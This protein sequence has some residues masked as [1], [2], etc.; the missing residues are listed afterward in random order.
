M[1]LTDKDLLSIQE[2]R[3]L[4]KQAKVAQRELA[5]LSQEEIDLIV[6]TMAKSAYANRIKLAKMAHKETGFGR[7]QDKVLKNAFASRDVLNA[8]KDMKT[9]GVINKSEEAKYM[10]VAV[11]VGVIA[12]LIPSTN[13]TSTVIYKALISVKAGNA[14]VFSPH[15]SALESIMET[16]KIMDEAGRNVGLPKGTLSVISQ[17]TPQATNE[18]MTNKDTDL[19]LATGGSAMVRA[20]Y[21]SGTPAIGVGPGNGPAFIERTADIP[22][23]VR[24]IMESKT[25]DNGTIC[26]SEQSVIVEEVSREKVMTEFKKRGGYFLPKEDAKKLENYILRPDG[27]MNPKIVGKA[28]QVI[29]DLAGII[30]PEDAQVLLAEENRVGKHAPYSREKLAPILAFYT[31]KNWE[32][33]CDLSIDILLEEGAGHTMSIHS[34]DDDVIQEFALRKPV[35][36]LLVNTSATLGG[37]GATTNLFPALTLGC[38]AVGGSSTSDNIAP[39]NLFNL[40]RIAW[41]VRELEDLRGEDIFEDEFKTVKPKDI[42][43]DEL[44]NLLVERVLEKLK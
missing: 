25:F 32:E 19:I 8:I 23:A 44:I 37:I 27:R 3:N 28:V 26:A 21:S 30:I 12:G 13:P 2:T 10:E 43:K 15:P 18:L 36:R 14:I 31:A 4:I 38:G 40:R 9:V 1:N 34:K 29:A 7:W 42:E 33:A 6:K 20:A 17:V 41:G 22:T 5:K 24:H 35:S 11:P 39:Q 16:V